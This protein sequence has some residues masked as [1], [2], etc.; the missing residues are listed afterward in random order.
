MW[1]YSFVLEAEK[2]REKRSLS[3]GLRLIGR[4]WS[5]FPWPSAR[6]KFLHCMTTDTEPVYR[7]VCL[8]TSQRWNR[9]RG[10]FV[11]PENSSHTQQYGLGLKLRIGLNL[12]LGLRLG[13]G[14]RLGLG[15][16]L[17]LRLVLGLR[18]ALVT[19]WQYGG[20]KNFPGATNFPRHRYQIILLGDRGICVWTT[21]LRSLPGSVLMR[22][23]TC[24]SELPQDYKSDTF[25]LDYRAIKSDDRVKCTNLGPSRRRRRHYNKTKISIHLSLQRKCTSATVSTQ[26]YWQFSSFYQ[27]CHF[28]L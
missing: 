14:L 17:G 22:S 6:H 12:G 2:M 5:P 19:L 3:R 8:F 28:T 21:C 25:P 13:V 27:R 10:K 24:A 18:L 11:A 9:C 20:G 16:G 15:L 4:C 7:A 23:R 1:A 26:T